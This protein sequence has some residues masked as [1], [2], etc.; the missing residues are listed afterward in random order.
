[1]ANLNPQWLRSFATLSE[2]QSFTRTAERLGIT[3]AAV[4]QHLRYL[5]ARFGLLIVRKKRQFDL[6]P[7]GNVLLD[8]CRDID[9]AD[10]RLS[11][12]LN[13][14]DEEHGD[15]SLITPGSIGLRC[16]PLLLALQQAFPGLAVRHRFAPDDEVL[17]AVLHNRYEMGLITRK[18]DDNRLAAER[19]AQEPLELVFPAKEKVESWQDLARLGYIDHPDGPA[20][21]ARLL[22]RHFPGNPGVRSLKCRG[23]SNQISLILEPVARGLGFAVLPKYARLAFARQ[24][25]IQVMDCAIPV[26]DT[27]WLIHRAEWPLSSRA[28]KALA[29]LRQHL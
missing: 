25:A 16:Y 18:P 7:A 11:L 23:F 19:F 3:Q 28:L 9:R 14:N 6:T 5:E 24:G 10:K 21:A 29:Y 26:V 20:M 2:L 27:I 12:R 22:S 13:E 15:I 4:S 17:E 8:Y 1:M